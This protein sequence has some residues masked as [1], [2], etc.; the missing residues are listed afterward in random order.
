MQDGSESRLALHC[1]IAAAGNS[2]WAPAY[3]A[4]G[5]WHIDALHHR[6]VGVVQTGGSPCTVAIGLGR[7]WV[8][9]PNAGR[10]IHCIR[11]RRRGADDAELP[12]T[13]RAHRI[14]ERIFLVEP[15]HVDRADV[16]V[17]GDMV[18]GE[19]IVDDV[20]KSRVT[21]AV[22]VQRHGQPP[23]HAA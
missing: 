4:P 13:L 20:A 23:G 17:G 9:N 2:I 3:F 14:G 15:M 21:H 22:L 1:T 7:V 8:A 6:V 5:V 16:G 18:A 12:N 11:D 19:V 10:V